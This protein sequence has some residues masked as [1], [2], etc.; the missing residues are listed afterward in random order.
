MY[1]Y[2]DDEDRAYVITNP[3]T[4][5]PWINY[6]TNRRLSAFISQQGGGL[7]WYWEPLMRRITRYHYIPA[8]GDQPGLYLY[9]KDYATGA[10]WNPHFAPTCTGLDHFTCRH[11]P[12]VTTFQSAKDGIEAVVRYAIPPDDDLLL[13]H[14]TVTNTNKTPAHLLAASY[15]EFGLLEYLREMLAWCYLKT[16]IGFYFRPDWQAICYNYHVFEAPFTPCMALGCTEA[17]AGYEASR[18]AF[19]GSNGSLERPAALVTERGL[20]DSVLPTGG[21]GCGVLGV[22]LELAAGESRSFAYRFALADTWDAVEA[23]F[24][25]YATQQAVLDGIQCSARYWDSMLAT[26]QVQSG[27]ATVDRFINTWTPYNNLITLTHARII[28]TDHMGLDG[29]RYRDTTQDALGVANLDPEYALSWM[30]RVFAQQTQDG[31][32]CYSFYPYI[33]NKPPS[34]EPHRSDNTVWQVYT[35]NNLVAETGELSLWEEEAPFRDGGKASLYD[36]TLRGLEHIAARRGPHGLPTMFHADW[37]DGLALFGDERAESVMLGM[38]LVYSCRELQEV[39]H[40]LGRK[41]DA[42]W[43]AQLA[44]ELDAVLNSPDVWDGGWYR[45]LLLSNGSLLG[46]ARCRQ[47][48]IF[49]NPQS[50]AVISGVGA[51]QGR[52]QQAMD[53]AADPPVRGCRGKAAPG[54][55]I[56]TA[57]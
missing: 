34:D 41:D 19:I 39:A 51:Y 18:D 15:L 40:R 10:L 1:G 28:S 3:A 42:A 25:K 30:R 6:L 32:G 29:H 48:S 36:H 13:W 26:L 8:P 50:W 54:S 46:S 38:Q 49:I 47:G 43:C 7:L 16:H 4:P 9:L 37:N 57:C 35:M 27:D 21:H 44:A 24:A 2:F 22:D 33:P 55:A 11:R 20:T 12:G 5:R 56:H 53:A 31:G 23:L 45:R 14:V 52:G 17:V